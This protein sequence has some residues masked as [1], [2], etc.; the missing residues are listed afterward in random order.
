MKTAYKIPLI[1]LGVVFGLLLVTNFVVGPVAKNYV[2]KHDKEL[3]GREVSVKRV[4]VN[5]FIGKLK[6]NELTLFEDD[7]TTPFVQFDRFESRIRLRDL[8]RHRLWVKHAVLSG[9]KVNIEQ[10]RDWFNFNSL[11][12]HLASRKTKESS[13]D[14][15]L[16]FNDVTIEKGGFRYADLALGNEFNLNDIALNV[17]SLDLSDLNTDVGLDL[18]LSDSAILHTDIRLSDN[19]KKYCINLKLNNLDIEV[20]EPYVQQKYPVDIVGGTLNL[21]VEARGLTDHILDFDMKGDLV[22][23]K[24]ALKDTEGNSLADIDSVFANFNRLSLNDR[25]MNFS[26]LHVFGL[27][28]DYVIDADSMANFDLVLDSYRRSDSLKMLL[29]T[30]TLSLGL[31]E[32]KPWKISIDDLALDGSQLFFEDHTLPETFHYEVSDIN[33]I[34]K[35]FTFDGENAVQLHAALNTV[36]KLHLKWQG[37]FDG[38]DNHNLTLMLS[39]VKVVDF[40]PYVIQW[41]GVPVENGTL[42]FHSQNVIS[43]GNLNGINKLQIADPEFGNKLKHFHPRFE[44]VPLRLGFYLLSDKHNNVSL[45]LPVSGDLNDPHFSYRKALAKVFSNVL[46]K[47]AASPFR[48][49]TDEE[50]NL[51]YIPFDPL[52]FDFTPEQY[53]MIDNVVATLQSRSDLSIILEEQV[54]YEEA[55]KEL[56]IMQLKHDFYFSEHSEMKPSDMDFLTNEAIR[57]IKLNDRDLCEYAAQYSSKHRLHSSK[58]VTSVAWEVYHERSEKMLPRLMARR[59]EMLCDYLWK[60]N[61]LS[62]EQISVT[63]IDESLMKSFV[64]PS[65]YEMHVFRYEDME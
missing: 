5:L 23:N 36:G 50:N 51:K 56:C 57:A 29:D 45:D 1:V 11:R 42:S 40:S 25:E 13:A 27:K 34:S 9:P 28:L 31:K 6:I 2:E 4:G 48:L 55:I 17:P 58:D 49:M 21:D 38:R 12:E 44:K 59:N 33:L 65:R 64:K 14:F 63:T 7:D 19:A 10:D 60:A 20:I 52:Q 47:V 32:K 43:N 53:V 18:R 16:V 39:N 30:D 8:L 37:R 62:P 41:F 54:Q 3:L 24:V 22:L 26:K 15:G 61:G 35:H 46:A